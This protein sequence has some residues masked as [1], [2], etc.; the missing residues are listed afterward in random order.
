MDAHL[1][2]V[3]D[4]ETLRTGL[5]DFFRSQGFEVSA[6]RDGDEGRAALGAGGFDLVLLDLMLPGPGG[7]ELLR[8]LRQRDRETPVIILTA[9][10][11]ENDKV[12]GLE[13]GADDYVTKPF[14]LREVTARVRAQLRRVEVAAGGIPRRL[15]I[16]GASVELDAYEL[17]R[18]GTTHA[19]S[20]KEA[21]LLELLYRH[22]GSVVSR[23][24]FLDEVW[25]SDRFVSNRTID[26]HILHLRKK[27]EEDPG[28]P[29]HLLTVH[30]VGYRLCL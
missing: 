1:L 29:P 5:R 30:G 22:A 11:E 7:L 4:D 25:G 6:A 12:L 28:N 18:D 24:R 20:P 19:L 15:Q 3:E 27:L 23:N 17:T 9:R 8:E 26:T 13:M 10:G 16:G 14:G 21:G 2:I